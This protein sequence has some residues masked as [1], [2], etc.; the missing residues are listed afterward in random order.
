MPTSAMAASYQALSLEGVRFV[1]VVGHELTLQVAW[2]AGNT[3]TALP[4]FLATTRQIAAQII[5]SPLVPGHLPP[6][7]PSARGA[8]PRHR[9][10]V[11][12]AAVLT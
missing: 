9:R 12:I 6:A 7:E 1:P 8:V 2:A 10:A 3:D 11:A 5:G 4:G